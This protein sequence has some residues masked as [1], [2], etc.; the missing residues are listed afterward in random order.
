MNRIKAL[1]FDLDGTL[2]P[3]GYDKISDETV[4]ILNS[5]KNDYR[6][7]LVTGRFV[8]DLDDVKKISFD[9]IIANNGQILVDNTGQREVNRLDKNDIINLIEYLKQRSI[10]VTVYEEDF[11]YLTAV[12][13][14]AELF[15]N[16]FDISM[17]PLK[18]EI[19]DINKIV[20]MT[21]FA[22]EKEIAPVLEMMT[23][24]K[25]VVWN[26]LSIDLVPLYSDKG[27]ALIKAAARLAIKGEE[28]LCF[29][30]GDNDIS[31]FKVCGYSC[32]MADGNE[33]LKKTATV[34]RSNII[35]GLKYFKIIN[36]EKK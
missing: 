11:C 4:T 2:L 13:K 33:L 12:N 27:H 5:L 29:G 16:T 14:R 18:D 30:D 9:M 19:T 31:M 3:Y 15:Y 17:P 26:G 28:I 23:E 22:E 7:F 6:L 8:L 36:E 35:E 32:A 34:V 10:P 25:A 21:V 1:A 24:T 20:M